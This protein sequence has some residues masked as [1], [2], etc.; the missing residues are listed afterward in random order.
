M[1]QPQYYR[2]KVKDISRVL[3]ILLALGLT[4]WEFVRANKL[5]SV[6]ASF[7]IL[8]ILTLCLFNLI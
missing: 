6:L 1:R 4:L 3:V 2:N 5:F 7:V 8:T